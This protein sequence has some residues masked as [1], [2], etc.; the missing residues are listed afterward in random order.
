MKKQVNL[1]KKGLPFSS[2]AA[3]AAAPAPADAATAAP[4]GT[5]ANLDLPKNGKINY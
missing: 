4:V 5:L 1:I 2:V 3:G